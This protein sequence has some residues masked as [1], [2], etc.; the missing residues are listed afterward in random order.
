MMQNQVKTRILRICVL[1]FLI[2]KNLK[3]YYYYYYYFNLKIG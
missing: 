3:I 2:I 1:F